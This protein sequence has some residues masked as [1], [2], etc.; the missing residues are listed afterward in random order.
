MSYTGPVP[1]N[2][3]QSTEFPGDPLGSPALSP[4]DPLTGG[5]QD[6]GYQYTVPPAPGM[7]NPMVQQPAYSV[8][9][10]VPA[11]QLGMQPEH[12]A[13]MMRGGGILF[14]A[15]LG[16]AGTK[17]AAKG[18]VKAVRYLIGAG[19]GIAAMKAVKASG[20]RVR[21]AAPAAALA[22]GWLSGKGVKV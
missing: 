8:R 18:K 17:F 9:D 3:A 10:G 4:G 16:A 7:D 21:A 14:A 20:F 11:N 5:S 15:L 1:D 2:Y 22:A 6:A 19:A 13:A 12:K